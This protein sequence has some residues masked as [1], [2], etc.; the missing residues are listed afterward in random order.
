MKFFARIALPVIGM[1]CLVSACGQKG[2]LILPVKPP[3]IS[4]P[5]P[6]AQP[7]PEAPSDDEQPV[8]DKS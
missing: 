4:T 3:A 5:Y 1:L 2:K 6:V 7:K 8:Q